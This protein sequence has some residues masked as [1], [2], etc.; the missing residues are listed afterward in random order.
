MPFTMPDVFALGFFLTCWSIYHIFVERA[1]IGR[2][3]LNNLMNE[4]RLRWMIEMQAREARIVDSAIMNTL[5]SG[6]AFFASTS[7]LALGGALALL[8]G[9]DDAL[10]I[11]GD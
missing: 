2:R 4:Y 6:N 5:Q 10:R 9:A 8:R 1:P 11:V 7:L 3:A